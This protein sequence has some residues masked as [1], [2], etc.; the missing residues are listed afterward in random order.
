MKIEN[1]I[2]AHKLLDVPTMS[3]EQ[4]AKH[5]NVTIAFIKKQLKRGIEVESEHTTDN[6]IASEIAR[7][8]IKEDPNY[9]VKLKTIEKD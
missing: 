1:L 4:L 7:D 8:H 5:H 2:E 3:V 9:Y 6:E